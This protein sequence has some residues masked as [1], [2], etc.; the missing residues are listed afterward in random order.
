MMMTLSKPHAVLIGLIALITISGLAYTL[1]GMKPA[2]SNASA[3]GAPEAK[4][5]GECAQA[6]S[7]TRRLKPLAKG[8]LAALAIIDKPQ[9]LPDLAFNNAEGKPVTLKDFR[10]KTILLNLWATWCAPCRHEMPALNTLQT[11]L[12][13]DRF[14]VVAINIDTRNLDKPA[15]WLKDNA[16]TNLSYYADPQAKIF[17]DLKRIGKAVGM[18]AS[19]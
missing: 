6:N 3:P 16:I 10:G 7:V 17:Q 12:G 19:S 5:D 13:S 2:S 18:P 9:N 1:Y 11:S 15:Q 14:E 4:V 8:E